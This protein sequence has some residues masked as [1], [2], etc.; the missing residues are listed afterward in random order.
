LSLAAALTTWN[1]VAG[2]ELAFLL[3]DDAEIWE[4]GGR[5]NPEALLRW[6]WLAKQVHTL[7]KRSSDGDGDEQVR[8]FCLPSAVAVARVS[9]RRT[10]SATR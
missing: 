10:R 1:F 9:S 4:E 8:A 2:W 5:Y 3:D 6:T 7:A